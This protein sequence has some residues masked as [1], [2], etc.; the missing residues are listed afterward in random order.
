MDFQ[1]K[2]CLNKSDLIIYSKNKIVVLYNQKLGKH[3]ILSK[4]VY[5]F[6]ENAD[7]EQISINEFI[8]CFQDREDKKYIK[9][10]IVNMIKAGIILHK[11]YDKEIEEQFLINSAYLCLTNRCNLKCK[12]CCSSCSDKE[13]DCLSTE[14]IKKIIDTL[15]ELNISNIVLTGG[16][17]LLRY[18]FEEIVIYAKKQIPKVNLILSTNSI[19]INDKNIDFI[20]NNFNKIDIS[21]DG[22]DEETCSQ[23][24]GKGVFG[25]VLDS[26]DKLKIKGFVNISLSMVFGQKND[27][28]KEDFIKLN[29]S[30]GTNPVM[31]YF[32]PTGR[33]LENKDQ[34]LYDDTILPITIPEMLVD[35][36]KKSKRISSCACN[37]LKSQIFINYDGNIYPCPS[38]VKDIYNAGSIFDSDIINVLKNKNTNSLGAYKNIEK[39]YPYNFE[40][41]KD[42]DVNIFCWHCPAI[43]DSVKDNDAEFN[44]WCNLMK[45]NLNRIIW[46]EEGE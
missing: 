9:Q 5:G 14:D 44:K 42:C 23:T 19:L 25:K 4:E 39:I 27:Y 38:L 6:F 2:V 26:V 37:A 22:V 11:N 45:S 18:D 10:V 1:S 43:L 28:L 13:N 15:K 29:E 20:I 7:S 33:G 30:I 34:Y 32:V 12:H 21:I 40:K 8:D 24:R 36:N 46:D 3:I 31:R 35:R 41:C 17:P 16:E